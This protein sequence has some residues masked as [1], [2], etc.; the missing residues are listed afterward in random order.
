VPPVE[1]VIDSPPEL[2]RVFAYRLAGLARGAA[3]VALALPGGSVAETFFP[4]LSASALDWQA[5]DLFWCDERAVPPN[6]LES[7]FRLAAD[8][9]LGR[10]TID[11]SRVHRMKADRHDLDRAAAEYEEEM[12]AAL[13]TPPRVDVALLGVGPDGH[14]CSLFP[15]H[16][17]LNERARHVAAITDAP[18]PPARRLT[19]T[20]PALADSLVVVAAFGASKAAA[21][22]EALENPESRL[23]VALAVRGAREALF[24]LD[25]A[26]AGE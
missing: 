18:K 8:L 5:I 15:D 20:F 7:N 25:A 14:V 21:I 22:R 2:A 1:T 4:V 11:P 12:I 13:G 17:L 19:L 6:H 23:P 3:R 9:L 10:A 16:P 24:L 26:A